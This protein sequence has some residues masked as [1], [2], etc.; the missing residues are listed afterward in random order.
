[1]TQELIAEGPQ[2]VPRVSAQKLTFIETF[3]GTLLAPVQTFNHLRD[4]CEHVASHLPAAVGVVAFVFALDALRLSSEKEMSWALV[5]IPTEVTAGIIIWLL[6]A[7]IVSLTGLCFGASAAKS[8][9]AF[10]TM[11]WSFLPWIFMGPISCLSAALGKAHVLFM[12]IPFCW[13]LL[14][15]IIAIKC[16]YDMKAW[17]ALVL[18]FLVPPMLSWFQLLQFIQGLSAVLGSL[19]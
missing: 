12:V 11:A 17:Q 8:R 2:N 5:N 13:V 4:D 1:M 19:F 9:T 3:I 15:Q 6:A 18:V 16:S 10:V 7:G 14:L